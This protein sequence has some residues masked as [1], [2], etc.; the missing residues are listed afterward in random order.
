M[1]IFCEYYNIS[2]G[3][4]FEG[5]NILN[6]KYSYQFLS[7]KYGLDIDEIKSI[8]DESSLKLFNFREKRIK[9]QK[10][11]KTIL[12]WNALAI[13]SFIKGYRITGNKTYLKTAKDAINFIEN[14]MKLTNDS[15]YRIYKN[16]VSKIP[17]YL[18]D[19]SFYVN[20]LLDL[21]EI[22]PNIEYLNMIIN[23][24]DH[25]IKNFWDSNENNFYYTSS[26]HESL[27]IRNK[28]LYDLA[29][30]SGNSIS[31]SNFIRL[32][33]V[34]G[35][36]DYIDFAERMM[37][38]SLSSAVENPFGFGCLLSSAYLYIKKPVEI[39]VFSKNT[40]IKETPLLDFINTAF[41]PN[42]IFSIID[43]ECNLKSLEEYALFQNKSLL[44]RND[45]EFVLMCKDFTCSPP[46]KDIEG[47]KDIL[48]SKL[49][50]ERIK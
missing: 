6:I 42:G 8:I 18:D 10:D 37:K 34:T 19:Y 41:I 50:K 17:A 1:N 25:L 14:K 22:N 31:I 26:F 4:N 13:S 33:H 2:E 9:P 43:N 15:L 3:G 39:T 48:F 23:Y 35:N 11:D 44:D 32:Y 36:R 7:K 45:D 29:I 38:S 5:K 16:D 12:S 40:Y 47:I 27:P 21:L 20:A 30:P 46:I 49:S 28:I 24:T